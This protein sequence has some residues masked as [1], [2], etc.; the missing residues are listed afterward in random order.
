MILGHIEKRKND[1]FYVYLGTWKPLHSI[2]IYNTNT[3]KIVVG[4]NII[5]IYDITNY[6]PKFVEAII[7]YKK[8][9]RG[10]NN[11]YIIIISKKTTRHYLSNI[12]RKTLFYNT[13]FISDLYYLN[14]NIPEKH[15]SVVGL[16]EEPVILAGKHAYL[17]TIPLRTLKNDKKTMEKYCEPWIY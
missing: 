4:H 2:R 11:S 7:D 8:L 13:I 10:K 6:T 14:L 16:P 3:L 17:V 9:I 5:V 12:K 1:K 15:E